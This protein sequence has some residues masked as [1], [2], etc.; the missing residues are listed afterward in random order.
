MT[1]VG[2]EKH[3]V[4]ILSK[5]SSGFVLTNVGMPTHSCGERAAEVRVV[6]ML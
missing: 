6:W 5:L 4:Y 3:H 2:S 1:W